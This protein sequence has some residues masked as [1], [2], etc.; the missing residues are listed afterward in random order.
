MITEPHR[1]PV[2]KKQAVLELLHSDDFL[3]DAEIAKKADTTIQYVR[4]VRCEER[5]ETLSDLNNP[6]ST[7]SGSNDDTAQGQS[8]ARQEKSGSNHSSDSNAK[9]GPKKQ[10]QTHRQFSRLSYDQRSV[11]GLISE[12]DRKKLW[13]DFLDKKSLPEIIKER[14]Y[15]PE[16]VWHEYQLFLRF[17]GF[18]VHEIQANLIRNISKS[19]DFL[20]SKFQQEEV[21][22]YNRTVQ[23]FKNKGYIGS[24]QFNY[25]LN[26]SQKIRYLEGKNSIENLSEELPWP[27]VRPKCTY[28]KRPVEGVIVS[29][30]YGTAERVLKSEDWRH[31]R[32]LNL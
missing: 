16:N 28:C 23:E 9:S 7:N 32:C 22:E 1:L 25:L 12:E 31:V 13:G 3:T 8:A 6:S 26:I 30:K 2:T 29:T 18:D 5:Q 20:L 14:G 4:K 15:Q 10:T 17:N 27:W 21:N 24:Q 19:M 11:I